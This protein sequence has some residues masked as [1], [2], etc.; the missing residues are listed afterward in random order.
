MQ[1]VI[2]CFPQ[3]A[4]MQPT[5]EEPPPSYSTAFM[6]SSAT[7]D[8]RRQQEELDRR[9]ADLERREEEMRRSL[10]AAG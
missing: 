4:V 6:A 9:A 1:P 5:I 7:E 2:K 3:P 8:L 10:N